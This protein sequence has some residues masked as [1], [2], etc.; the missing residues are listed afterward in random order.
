MIF[1]DTS[2][3]EHPVKILIG[4]LVIALNQIDYLILSIYFR[5]C[6]LL[7]IKLCITI[8]LCT[9]QNTPFE[10]GS[11]KASQKPLFW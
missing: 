5:F 8:K 11:T 6:G 7:Y 4:T 9:K 10:S 1:Y 3:P 2:V